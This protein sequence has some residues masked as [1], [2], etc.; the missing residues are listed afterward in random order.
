MCQ[1]WQKIRQGVRYVPKEEFA[2]AC[3]EMDFTNVKS[4]KISLDPFHKQNNSLR[5]FW[6]GISAPRV[7]STNPSFKVTTEIRNDKEAPYFLAELNN[8]KKYKFH[9]SEFPSA[10]LVKTFNR[11]LSK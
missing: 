3:K 9:T 4:I 7:R 11:I 2:K 1:M 6:F 8:G 10:D 5:N